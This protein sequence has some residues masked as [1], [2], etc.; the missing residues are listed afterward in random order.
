MRRRYNFRI[1]F[2]LFLNG[3]QVSA[4]IGQTPPDSL[5]AILQRLPFDE[6]AVVYLNTLSD[7]WGRNHPEASFLA[8]THSQVMADSLGLAEGEALAYSL[9]GRSSWYLGNYQP[10]LSFQ[11]EARNLYLSLGDSLGFANACCHIANV[12][13]QYG[14]YP[15]AMDNMVIALRL[16]EKWGDSTAIADS[17]YGMGILQAE[18]LDFTD[19]LTNYEKAL[20]ITRALGDKQRIADILNYIGRVW[21]KQEV[22]DKALEAHEQSLV[23]YRELGDEVG[24]SDY[25]N[26]V[27]SIYRRQGKYDQALDHFFE[28][29]EI[30][31]KLNDLEGLA[32]GY[33]DIGTTLTQKGSYRR[34]IEYLEKGLEISRKTG[35]KDD[36]R[37][38]LTSLSA[39]Y[40]SLGDFSRAYQYLRMATSVRDSLTNAQVN[41][42]VAQLHIQ[43]QSEKNQQ[44]ISLLEKESQLQKEKYRRNWAIFVG[45]L[46]VLAVFGGSMV[47]RSRLQTR[48]NRK[49]AS[50]NRDIIREKEKNEELLLNILPKEIAEELKIHKKAKARSYEEATV[51]FIDFEG[52]TK[53]S[54]KLSPRELVR[55]LHNCFE[56]FDHIVDKHGLEKIKTIGDAYM[57][58]AGI[59]VPDPDHAINTVRAALEIQAFMKNRNKQKQELG[60]LYFQARLGIHTGPVIAGVV[61]IRKFT[62]DI[63]G[64]T[65]NTASRMETTGEIGKVNISQDTYERIQTRFI[66]RYRGKVEAKHKGLIDMY[67]VEWEI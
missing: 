35:L 54:E 41:E 2:F 37:Y 57:C 28:A 49:L 26:N 34:A 66:C 58:A 42:Q 31:Q 45:F 40:D 29:L 60:E 3:L 8:A 64:D 1:V 5:P 20:A 56:A 14:N 19:A 63:W 6:S 9:M 7:S 33:N 16:R 65:V 24:I 48:L 50:K 36:V 12:Y 17:Y 43:Y 25:Y 62:Y 46:L 44:Q 23:L 10:A 21:R 55:E 52:F 22:Y 32:D 13:W 61:G 11:Q 4:G 39:V 15:L 18:L 27:G 51:M 53:L 47:Y 59:P 38:A 67:F 30:Q